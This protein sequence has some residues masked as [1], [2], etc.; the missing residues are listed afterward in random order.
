MTGTYSLR[1]YTSEKAPEDDSYHST[2]KDTHYFLDFWTR[3][4]FD[5][6]YI[7][8]E[9]DYDIRNAESLVNP[10][11]GKLRDYELFSIGISIGTDA[12]KLK[13]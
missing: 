13:K 6:F 9:F 8:F 2:R 3:Y 4:N 11:M 1:Y 12:L 5:D 7:K 10:D